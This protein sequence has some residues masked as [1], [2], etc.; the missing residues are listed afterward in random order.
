[1]R[2]EDSEGVTCW[3][4]PMIHNQLDLKIIHFPPVFSIEGL[5]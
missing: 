5:D 4:V 3:H 1:M 2:N